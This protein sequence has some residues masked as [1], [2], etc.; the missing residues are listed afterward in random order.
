MNIKMEK[1][2]IKLLKI[3]RNAFGINHLHFKAEYKQINKYRKI[4]CLYKI[5]LFCKSSNN[6]HLF[7]NI[8]HNLLKIIN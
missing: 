1:Y 3:L 7:L 6:L 8:N 2:R 4:K 5:L